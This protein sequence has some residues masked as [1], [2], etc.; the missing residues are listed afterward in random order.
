MSHISSGSETLYRILAKIPKNR[1]TTYKSLAKKMGNRKLARAVGNWLNK[2]PYPSKKVPCFRV[3]KSNGEIGGYALGVKA[4][5]RKLKRAGFDV[6]NGKVIDY[7]DVV[8]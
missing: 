1:L 3:I 8:W 4:K 7:K 5:V 6:K 2:N